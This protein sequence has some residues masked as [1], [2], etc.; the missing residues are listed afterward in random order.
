METKTL[1]LLTLL[2]AIAAQSTLKTAAETVIGDDGK[3][4]CHELAYL[5]ELSAV[6]ERQQTK[7][8][9]RAQDNSETTAM[10]SLAAAAAPS[11][12]QRAAFKVLATYGQQ[13]TAEA[14]RWVTKLPDELADLRK[15][16]TKRIAALKAAAITDAALK[17]K[18]K[19]NPEHGDTQKSCTVTIQPGPDTALSCPKIGGTAEPAIGTVEAKLTTATKIH[20]VDLT[21]F[22]KFI[23]FPKVKVIST[24]STAPF[25][26]TQD[27]AGKCKT[28]LGGTL[29]VGT[30]HLDFSFPT[31]VPEANE[32]KAQQ[33]DD[34]NMQLPTGPEQDK[35]LPWLNNK[36][37]TQ[38]LHKAQAA[39]KEDVTDLATVTYEHLKKSATFAAIVADVLTKQEPGSKTNPA[40]RQ[41]TVDKAI[42]EKFGPTDKEFQE[43]FLAG[44]KVKDVIYR[45]YGTDVKRS[46]GT[47]TSGEGIA[48]ALSYFTG[49][50]IKQEE[51]KIATNKEPSAAPKCD[52]KSQEKCDGNCDWDNK[53]AK[54]KAKEEVK[55]GGKGPKNTNTTGSNSF[56]IKTSPLWLA[57]L[58]LACHF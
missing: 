28:V 56:L 3:Q 36:L 31:T 16:L 54:C 48:V 2:A 34:G 44:L 21:A 35:V 6:L 26:T 52:G 38:Q 45:K 15:V 10:W 17:V 43:N 9:R 32:P 13:M 41:A 5:R 20:L 4:W 19:G 12:K 18:P 1:T 14:A 40:S 8:S 51:T 27:A 50:R 42:E 55:V 23:T 7:R 46:Y 58:L 37:L 47:T 33:I 24:G 22:D 30:H 49:L 25:D 29:T 53:E 11:T 57:F 39:L